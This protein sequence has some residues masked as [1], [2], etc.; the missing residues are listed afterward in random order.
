MDPS[1]S[2]IIISEQGISD[3]D[4]QKIVDKALNKFDGFPMKDKFVKSKGKLSNGIINIGDDFGTHWVCYSNQPHSINYFDSYGLTIPDVIRKRLEKVK[5][6]IV[7]SITR[8]QS[9]D[10]VLCGLFCIYVL[11]QLESGRTLDDILLDFDWENFESNDKKLINYF[12]EKFFRFIY[13]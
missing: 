9:D 10:S 6:P 11:I 2:T 7:E 3:L 8:L 5:K 12:K 4:L 1:K 13:K